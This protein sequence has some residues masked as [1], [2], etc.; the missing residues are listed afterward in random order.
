MNAMHSHCARAWRT[1]VDD[2]N[3]DGTPE[4]ALNDEPAL[5]F[6][7]KFRTVDVK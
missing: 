3:P 7:R 6:A 5:S 2:G 1:P 4:K